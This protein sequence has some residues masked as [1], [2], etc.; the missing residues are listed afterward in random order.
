MTVWA[1]RVG[2]CFPGVLF[3]LGH[4]SPGLRVAQAKKNVSSPSPRP[5]LPVHLRRR[6]VAQRLVRPLLVVEREVPPQPLAQLRHRLVAA[7]VQL[8]VLHTPPKTLHKDVIQAPAPPVH[9][10]L[11]PPRP[12]PPLKPPAVNC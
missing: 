4:P 6:P 12:H 11:N 2:P 8:L 9:A 10:H 1:A 5:S 7:Q 3:R